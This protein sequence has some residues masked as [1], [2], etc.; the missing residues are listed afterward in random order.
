MCNV[1][2][3]RAFLRSER[4]QGLRRPDSRGLRASDSQVSLGCVQ[5][6]RSSSAALNQELK[7]SLARGPANKVI[8]I[9]MLEDSLGEIKLSLAALVEQEKRSLRENEHAQQSRKPR[10]RCPWPLAR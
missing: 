5:K 1:S 7:Q 8:R 3:L 4:C 10:L 2:E 9:S 6:R